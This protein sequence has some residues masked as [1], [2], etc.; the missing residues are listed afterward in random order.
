MG[1]LEAAGSSRECSMKAIIWLNITASCM[2]QCTSCMAPLV[3]PEGMWFSGMACED[4]G[5]ARTT[6]TTVLRGL[7]PDDITR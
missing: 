5:G 4:V 3:E 7:L 1:S 2:P 6:W